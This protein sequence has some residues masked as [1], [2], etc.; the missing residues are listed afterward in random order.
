ML[1]YYSLRLKLAQVTFI[2]IQIMLVQCFL[3][4]LMEM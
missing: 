4:L 3:F 1:R 2:M